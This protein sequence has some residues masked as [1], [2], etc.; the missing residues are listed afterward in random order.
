VYQAE[1][2]ETALWRWPHSLLETAQRAVLGAD[3][4]SRA[5]QYASFLRRVK[6]P[7]SLTL[8]PRAL[9][10]KEK[11]LGKKWKLKT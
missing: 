11:N 2:A 7:R 3:G 10:S 9:S 1:K 6:I 4:T 5:S 8:R